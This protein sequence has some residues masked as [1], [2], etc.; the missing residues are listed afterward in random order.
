MWGGDAPPETLAARMARATKVAACS[1]R[2]GGDVRCATCELRFSIYA[3]WS[4]V[5]RLWSMVF[6]LWNGGGGKGRAITAGLRPAGVCRIW[7]GRESIARRRCAG[8]CASGVATA[9][10]PSVSRRE[11]DILLVFRL[12]RRD[13]PI[14]GASP[15]HS[16]VG[17]QRV[18]LSEALMRCA[19][20]DLRLT[21]CE[22][23]SWVK[24]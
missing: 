17:L 11:R 6:G 8:Y 20:C 22:S 2:K 21:I 10:R 24:G 13:G 5:L 9:H 19:I 7:P 12:P 18:G 3:L 14:G 23:R 4:K 15:P 16:R 1:P